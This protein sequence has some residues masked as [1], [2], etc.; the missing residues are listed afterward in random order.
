MFGVVALLGLLVTVGCVSLEVGTEST[1]PPTISTLA[2][3]YV[4]LEGIT[5]Y[6]GTILRIGLWHMD[7]RPGEIFSLDIWPLVGFGVGLVGVRAHVLPVDAGVGVIW[8]QPVP[9]VQM[10]PMESVK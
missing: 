10:A 2:S 1:R 3:A 4:G 8:Y 5:P 9:C 6:D 7:A